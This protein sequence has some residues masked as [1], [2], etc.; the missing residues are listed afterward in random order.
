MESK[1][2]FD[3]LCA[4]TTE[5]TL[6]CMIPRKMDSQTLAAVELPEGARRALKST[7]F[8]SELSSLGSFHKLLRLRL[9]ITQQ[10]LVGDHTSSV[11]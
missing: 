8:G 5:L 4:G 7:A 3:L 9:Q 2:D 6:C 10:H 1:N 11:I